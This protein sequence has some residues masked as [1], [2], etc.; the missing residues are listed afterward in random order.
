MAASVCLMMISVPPE[1]TRTPM[2]VVATTPLSYPGPRNWK[3]LPTVF[4]LSSVPLS[5]SVKT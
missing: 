1:P 2:P 3:V 5:A 4:I